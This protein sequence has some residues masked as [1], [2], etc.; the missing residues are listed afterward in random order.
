MNVIVNPPKPGEPSHESF[1]EEKTAVLND[2]A[3]KAKLV[4]TLF[5][6][7]PGYKC[8]P[9]MGAMYAFPKIDLPAKAKDAAKVSRLYFN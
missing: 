5:N 4:E 7:L 2:L 1:T 3:K 6:E 9:V 8:Q